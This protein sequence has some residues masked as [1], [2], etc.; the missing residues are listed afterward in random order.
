MSSITLEQI[1]E[2]LE[3]T[4]EEVEVEAEFVPA[5][6]ETLTRMLELSS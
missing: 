5:A 6:K 4:A 2:A 3:N 1:A